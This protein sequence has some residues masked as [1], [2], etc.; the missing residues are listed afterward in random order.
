MPARKQQLKLGLFF[1]PTGHHTASWRHPEAQADAGV[2]FA[3][4]MA[5]ARA[6]EAAKLDMI[7]F[8]DSLAVRAKN[9]R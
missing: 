6:A 1:A 8:A 7:F 5:V 4:Y 3:H 9:K 2:N